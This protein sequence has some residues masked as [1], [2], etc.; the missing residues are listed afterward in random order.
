MVANVIVLEKKTSSCLAGDLTGDKE[1]SE[2]AVVSEEESEEFEEVS[3]ESEDSSAVSMEEPVASLEQTVREMLV[4][5]GE[6]MRTTASSEG[7]S[8][9]RLPVGPEDSD[10]KLTVACGFSS[11]A[12]GACGFSSGLGP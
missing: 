2:V 3:V 7:P 9:G 1:E 8:P 11:G 5:E 12:C 10:G 4:L 6:V